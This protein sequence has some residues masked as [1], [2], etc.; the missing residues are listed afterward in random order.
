MSAKLA[1]FGGEPAVPADQRNVPWPVIAPS[2]EQALLRVLASGKFTSSSKDEQEVRGLEQEWAQFVGTRYSVAVNS[3]TAA[4]AVALTAL[5]VQP[6]DEVIVPALSY[7]A[8]GLA[9]LHQLAIPVFVDIDPATFNIDVRQIEAKITPRTRAI[10]P[11]H[12]HGLP[13][14]MDAIRA[15]ASKH[16]LVIVEDAAQAQG[17]AYQGKLVGALGDIGAFSLNVEKNIP[18][19]GEGGLVTM[20]DPE[21]YAR[22]KM[23]RQMGEEIESD[24]PRAYVS[25]VLGW[26]YKLS[27]MQ[28]AFTRSQMS[29]YAEDQAARER[30]I[31]ALLGKLAELPGVIV[32]RTLPDRTHVW[33]ILRFRFDPEAAGLT[34]VA[35]GRFRQA[36]RRALAA[37]GVQVSQYQLIPL[38]GQPVFAEQHG[39]G[40][41][42]PWTIA[43][44]SPQA[45]AI[46]EYP[47]TLAVIED[48]LCLRRVHLN[49]GSGPLLE[50]YA[51]AF[52]KIWD[53]LDRIGRIAQS[54]RYEAPWETV[55][56]RRQASVADVA[57]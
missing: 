13:A 34:G 44:T 53:N 36:L 3:G 56:K 31:A 18:T 38:P 9:A 43:G 40:R 30:N 26:N 55:L 45:Y 50:L 32:P 8:S 47:N 48:S 46:E 49:P 10:M 23:L 6:G 14:D 4:L 42:Y 41:G 7:V 57:N 22:C 1:M 2:D 25:Y 5:G 15:I 12:L 35:P 29:R 54:M 28:A 19:C 39:F 16:G 11:V 33:H 52:C 21:L 24:V 17:A 51:N 37:E 27:A 20:D